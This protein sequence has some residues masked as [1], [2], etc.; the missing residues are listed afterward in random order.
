MFQLNDIT[1][2][3]KKKKRVGRG[4]SRGGTSAKGHKGQKARSG[5]KISAAFEGGQMP[6]VRR[7]PKRGFNNTKFA[8]E[9]KIVSLQCLH[10][11][12]NDGDTVNKQV[13]LDRGIIK[14]KGKFALKVLGTGELAKKLDIEADAFSKS[15]KAAIENAG[16]TA[17]VETGATKTG[18]TKSETSEIKEM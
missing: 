14:G 13:L 16:G 2:V 17:T 6:L 5:P 12:F 7:L 11:T 8:T 10:D 1:P 18:K 15:A 9:V 4:G 3:C